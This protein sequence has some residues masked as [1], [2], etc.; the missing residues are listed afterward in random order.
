MKDKTLLVIAPGND[1]PYGDKQYNLL[2]AGT[3][4][5]IATHV[6]SCS[7]YAYHD[8]YDRQT[9]RKADIAKRFGEVDVKFINEAGIT[10][11]EM[12]RRNKEWYHGGITN[13]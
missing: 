3:G 2:V 1:T 8:L 6:C 7:G 5:L 11:E 12:Q 4:E 10:E 13:T 9:E